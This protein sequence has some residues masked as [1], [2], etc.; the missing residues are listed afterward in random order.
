M[1]QPVLIDEHLRVFRFV[2]L[3]TSCLASAIKLLVQQVY[4]LWRAE[5]RRSGGAEGMPWSAVT[6]SEIILSNLGL[7]RVDDSGQIAVHF[8]E[9][10]AQLVRIRPVAMPHE[11][12]ALVSSAEQGL[13]HS[14]SPSGSRSI[15]AVIASASKA[16]KS[17]E[18]RT[19]AG[20]SIL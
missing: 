20:E 1:R 17:A 7:E 9:R 6:A 14:S 13:G 3:L 18:R 16:G 15:M 19:A 2:A 12:R 10:E 4:H 11:V 5:C 8:A